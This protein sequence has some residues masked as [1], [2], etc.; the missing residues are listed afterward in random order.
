MWG[1]YEPLNTPSS[2]SQGSNSQTNTSSTDLSQQSFGQRLLYGGNLQLAFGT[3][4]IVEISPRIG[5]RVTEDLVS[6]VGVNYIYFGVSENY[7]YPGSPSTDFT[8][9]GANIFSTYNLPIGLP[10]AVHGEYEALNFDVY[11]PFLNEVNKEWVS[12]LRLGGA[13]V[14]RIGQGGGAVYFMALYDVLHDPNR[15][16]NQGSP[17]TIRVSFMF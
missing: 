9:W 7:Y 15:S 3:V 10:L 6:G 8:V 5:Y 12:A 13:F 2:N 16:L 17:W 11:D 14:Q 4:T 1:Q